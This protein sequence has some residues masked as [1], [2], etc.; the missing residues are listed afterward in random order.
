MVGHEVAVGRGGASDEG[1]VP[2]RWFGLGFAFGTIRLKD[3]RARD[4]AA[5][6]CAK[7]AG[8]CG[9]ADAAAGCTD[10]AGQGCHPGGGAG[11]S[12]AAGNT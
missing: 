1:G 8:G 12:G 2:G 5:A 7:P 9:S 4:V 11:G 6:S 3:S 10:C